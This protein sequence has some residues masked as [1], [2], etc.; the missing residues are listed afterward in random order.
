MTKIHNKK[1]IITIEEYVEERL[2]ESDF[3]EI[4]EIARDGLTY[5][6]EGWDDKELN[7]HH[8]LNQ[9]LFH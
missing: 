3:K 1:G 9:S 7:N 5:W 8:I 2:S 4:I 6:Y